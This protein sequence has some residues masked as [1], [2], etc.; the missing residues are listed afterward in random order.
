LR[1]TGL[2]DGALTIEIYGTVV[3]KVI[4]A[5]HGTGVKYKIF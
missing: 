1:L 5:I 2:S 4:E 3:D